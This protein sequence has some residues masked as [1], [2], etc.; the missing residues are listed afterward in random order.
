MFSESELTVTLIDEGLMR[1]K[2]DRV[3]HVSSKHACEAFSILFKFFSR[4]LLSQNVYVYHY[5]NT[6]NVRVPLGTANQCLHSGYWSFE[7]FRWLS[8]VKSSNL[9]TSKTT[10]LRKPQISQWL[11]F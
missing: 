9:P 5:H 3:E 8:V 6:K 7:M 10:T 1:L 2:C 11:L 4:V